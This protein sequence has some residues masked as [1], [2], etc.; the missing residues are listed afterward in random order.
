MHHLG[1][2]FEVGAG[3]ADE[4]TLGPVWGPGVVEYMRL[5]AT[6]N[7]V[8]RAWAMPG[9]VP[10]QVGVALNGVVGADPLF[11]V[12][13]DPERT[14]ARA[15]IWAESANDVPLAIGRVVPWSAWWIVVRVENIGGAAIGCS[16]LFTVR[17]FAEDFFFA[18]TPRVVGVPAH[19]ARSAERGFRERVGAVG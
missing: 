7:V 4:E 12:V 5:A 2:T 14:G 6:S 9:R 17:V 3:V 8:V 10:R 16:V 1:A 18:P 15:G 19:V 13:S 11:N